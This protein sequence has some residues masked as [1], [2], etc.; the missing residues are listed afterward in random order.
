M[1]FLFFIFIFFKD[2]IYLC[3]RD[4]DSQQE[5]EHKGRLGG[6]AVKRLPSAQGMIP[7]LWD[8]A[9]HRAFHY[10]PASSSPTPPAC[11]PSLAACLYLCQ[12]NK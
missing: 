1:I 2:F 6:R 7:A 10:E 8:R 12:T 3:D 4:R 11:V 5:R 9:P